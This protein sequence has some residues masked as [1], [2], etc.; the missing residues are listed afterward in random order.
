MKKK[1]T[2]YIDEAIWRKF[3]ADCIQH[4]VVAS[5][6]LEEQAR[7]YFETTSAEPNDSQN[8]SQSERTPKRKR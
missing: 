4:G 6:V 8:N 5:Q 2:L 7:R 1:V 3:R